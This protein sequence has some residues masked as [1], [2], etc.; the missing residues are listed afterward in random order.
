MNSTKPPRLAR[1]TALLGLASIAAPLAARAQVTPLPPST[2]APP[3]PPVI[4]APSPP[5]PPRPAAAPTAAIDKSKTYYVFFDG[6]IDVNSMRA[7]RHQLTALVEAGVAQVVLVINSG[8][9]QVLETLVTYS[10]IRA[11]P[12]AV[13]TH[14]Q[15]MVASAATV[16]FLAGDNRSADANAHFLF[17]PTQA[18]MAGLMGEQQMGEQAAQLRTVADT[19]AQIYRDRTGLTADQV[20][21]FRRN[22]VIYTADQ[23]KALGVVQSVADLKLPGPEAARIVFIE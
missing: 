19:T 13:A 22:E 20:E 7:L 23:A 4:T 15:G 16:L 9:G 6:S 18:P 1:R 14:A 10:F 21:Q 3:P 11:L 17:H 5:T 2:V 12:I 8:G